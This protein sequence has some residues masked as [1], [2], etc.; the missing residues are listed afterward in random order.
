MAIA[1]INKFISIAVPVAPGE[2]KVYEVPTGV[3]AIL[4]YAQVSNVGVS[5]YPSTTL[6][7]RRESR[8][9]GNKRDTRII[10]DIEVPPNDAAI[11][12]DGRLVL[13]KDVSTIDSIFLKGNQTGIN[14]IMDVQYDEPSGI[15]T[16]TTYSAHGFNVSD[17][18]TLAGISFN[19]S[20]STGITTTIFPDPQRSYTIDTVPTTTTFTSVLGSSNG[21]NH[22]YV[23]ARHSFLRGRSNAVT[24]VSSSSN[25]QEGGTNNGTQFAPTNVIYE[26]AT[27]IATFTYN[28]HGLSSNDTVSLTDNSLIFSCSADNFSTEHSYPRSTDPASTSNSELNNGVLSIVRVDANNFYVN[29]GL[30]TA[31]GYVGPLQMEF[32]ASILENSST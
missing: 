16:F 28:S 19:C 30:S 27:G 25:G 15:A 21:I 14:T 4:L 31:G 6:I 8:S 32:F 1:P 13:Q 17:D 12:V 7:H 26:G 20:N 22:T 5:T 9:T 23:S 10:K 18:I 29:V 24:V 11:L 2:Q 3:T